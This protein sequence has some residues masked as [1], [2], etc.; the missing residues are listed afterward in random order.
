MKSRKFRT[1]I[2]SNSR[3]FK[4]IGI[5]FVIPIALSITGSL[6]FL[7]AGWNLITQSYALGS[8]LFS[9][10]SINLNQV[11][12]KINNQDVY[13][14]DIGQVFATLK[15]PSIGVEKPIIHGDGE[16][17]LKKGVGHYAGSTLPGEKGNFVIDGHRDT[18]FKKLEGIKENDQVFIETQWG[19]YEYKV[20]EIKI[21]KPTE[22]DVIE[23]TNYEK[24]TMYTCYPFDYIGNAPERFVVDGEFVTVHNN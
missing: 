19:T 11:S 2:K 3:V 22:R 6:I 15:I 17:E 7:S 8:T 12:F 9:K 4:K 1:F 10:P 13:R 20:K 24:L 14:P 23:P 18:V 5:T 16:D 21:V